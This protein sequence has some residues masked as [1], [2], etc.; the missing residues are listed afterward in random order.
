MTHVLDPY[1]A[2]GWVS[3]A[4]YERD[5][6]LDETRSALSSLI[7]EAMLGV[8]DSSGKRAVSTKQ[9]AKHVK[10][11]SKSTQAKQLKWSLQLLIS[12]AEAMMTDAWDVDVDVPHF[13]YLLMTLCAA[14]SSDKRLLLLADNIVSEL[15]LACAANDDLKNAMDDTPDEDEYIDELQVDYDKHSSKALELLHK[16]YAR[17]ASHT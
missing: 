13:R 16:F 10:I 8:R 2:G 6:E 5:E 12:K 3:I 11:Q 7:R 14:A 9:I 1:I 15:R 17:C 4:D